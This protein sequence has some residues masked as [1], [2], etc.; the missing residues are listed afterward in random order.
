MNLQRIQV[1]ED[2]EQEDDAQQVFQ[3]AKEDGVV[4]IET[5]D[6]KTLITSQIGG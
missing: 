3:L 6:V 5:P 1:N 2:S 4:T